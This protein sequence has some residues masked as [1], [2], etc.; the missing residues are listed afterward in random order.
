MPVVADG[1]P[2]FLGLGETH[3]DPI[4]LGEPGEVGEQVGWVAALGDE[5]EI[6]VGPLDGIGSPAPERTTAGPATSGWRPPTG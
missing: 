6:V 3:C 1:A 4:G 2:A 5:E